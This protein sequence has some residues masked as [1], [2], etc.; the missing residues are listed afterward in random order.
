MH[1]SDPSGPVQR[2]RRSTLRVG[3][4]LAAM[5]V[6]ASACSGSPPAVSEP[7]APEP[8]AAEQPLTSD[9]PVDSVEPDVAGQIVGGAW[10]SVAEFPWMTGILDRSVA[11]PY[12][13]QFCGGVRVSQTKVLTAAHC[14]VRD[15]V[16]GPASAF[17]ILYGTSTLS[18]GAGTRAQVTGVAVHPFYSEASSRNDLAV[19]TVAAP[20]SAAPT[21]EVVTPE[22]DNNT[23]PGRIA[24]LA[25]WGCSDLEPN[26]YGNCTSYPELLRRADLPIHS[27]WYCDAAIPGFDEATM[28]CAGTVSRL[29]TADD[30]CYG[31]SGGPLSVAGARG[32][33]VVGLVSFGPGCGGAPTAYTRLAVYGSW[34]ASNGV[35]LR[36]APFAPASLSPQVRG[37]YQP[38]TGDFNGDGRSDVYWYAPGAATDS[39]WL[40]SPSGPVPGPPTRQVYGTYRPVVGDVDADGDDDL[41]WYAPG[42][43]A[44]TLWRGS[45]SGSFSSEPGRPVNGTYLPVVGDFDATQGDDIYWYAAR[46][47]HRRAVAVEP[48]RPDVVHLDRRPPGQRG[49]HTGQRQLR[50]HRRR[51]HL[52]VRTGRRGGLPVAQFA[53]RACSRARRCCS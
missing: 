42:R 35:P 10:A 25:G 26:V 14:V 36:S 39:L 15:G 28:L 33:L 31:D 48:C 29:G 47:R 37:S 4:A 12:Q 23:A 1:H 16:T 6:L 32:P 7:S 11:D 18:F 17:D 50:R 13:A 46:A 43:G 2:V 51:R 20:P 3:V 45:P 44:E 24:K 49:V 38:L 8:P 22:S 41:F 52:L 53:D 27:T 30:A 19:L 9:S 40:G 34:L 5:A 21:I